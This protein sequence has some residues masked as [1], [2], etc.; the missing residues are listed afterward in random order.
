MGGSLFSSKFSSFS[1]KKIKNKKKYSSFPS[2][3]CATSFSMIFSCSSYCQK[4]RKK[5]KILFFCFLRG[6]LYFHQNFLLT[7]VNKEERKKNSSSL[8]LRGVLYFQ[9]YFLLLHVTK[10]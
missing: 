5:K 2:L 1:L 3:R 8:S 10:K 4:R 7:P 9:L 6:V